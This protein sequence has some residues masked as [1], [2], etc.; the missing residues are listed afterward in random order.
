[1]EDDARNTLKML[2]L[3]TAFEAY[4]S[5]ILSEEDFLIYF[6]GDF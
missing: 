2:F 3:G 1:M 6:K 5:Y 4:L